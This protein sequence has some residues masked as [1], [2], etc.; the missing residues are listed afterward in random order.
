MFVDIQLCQRTDIDLEFAFFQEGMTQFVIKSMDSL[1]NEDI[2]FPKLKE[3]SPVFPVACHKVKYRQ[4]NALATKKSQHIFVEF[5]HV[6]CFQAFII[7]LTVFIQRCIFS[8]F[9][10]VVYSDR[11]RLHAMCCELD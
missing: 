1:D 7:S 3:I 9:E 2:L 8:V 6:Q 4:F 11:M 5:L 10:I